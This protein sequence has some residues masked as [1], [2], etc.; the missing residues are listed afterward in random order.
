M[1]LA[2]GSAPQCVCALGAELGEG[3]IWFGRKVWFVDIKR[4]RVHRFDPE[5]GDLATWPSPSPPGFIA[6][7]ASGGFVCGLKSGLHRFDPATGRFDLLVQVEAPEL[8]NRLNDGFVDAEGRLWFGSMHDPEADLTGVLYRLGPTGAPEAMD[9]GYCITNGPALSPDGRVL[10]HTDTL[11]R[12]IYAFDLSADGGVER[13][14]EFVRIERPGAYPD[15]PVV[16]AEGCLWTGLFGGWGVERYDPDGKLMER[17][18]FPCANVTKVAFGGDDLKT[19]FVT[20]ARK[21]LSDA[22]L[23]AQPLAGGLFRIDGTV[24]GQPQHEVRH[25]V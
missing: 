9:R 24:A 5:T 2:A 10:Y 14:R 1:G 3:P 17:I 25:G 23:T 11:E 21:G 12:V 4:S 15:G 7:V 13:R 8:D 18:E 6:P 22:D 16:D 20:T 19:L